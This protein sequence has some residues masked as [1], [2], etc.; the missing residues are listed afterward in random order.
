MLSFPAQVWAALQGTQ[1]GYV[2]A[3]V[4]YQGR[5]VELRVASGSVSVNGDQS[6]QSSG[7]CLV[8]GGGPVSLVPRVE[9][10]LLAPFGQ[11]LSLFR[12]VRVGSREWSVP[13]GTFG[14][15]DASGF[16]EWK[17]DGRVL[18]WAVELKFSD[19]LRRVERDD[20][21]SVDGPQSGATVWD[22]VARL[23]PVPIQRTLDDAPVS[24]A[25]TYG[26]RLKAVETLFGLLDC[27][28]HLTRAGVLTARRVDRWLT[29][30]ELDF[31]VDA[32]IDWSES[33]SGEFFN[34]VAVSSSADPTVVGFAVLDDASNPLS[35]GR[36]GG[37][38]LK[39]SSPLYSTP[40]EAQSGAETRLASLQTRRSQVVSVSGTP[41]LL[42]LEPGDFGRFSDPVSGRTLLGEVRTMDVPLD[43]TQPIRLGL[44]TRRVDSF[45]PA[46]ALSGYGSGPYGAGPYGGA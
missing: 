36:A 45:T 5:Q 16:A 14:I 38:T 32:V 12:V 41:E 34:Q 27:R 21:L 42:L 3:V 24:T 25:V 33:M 13:L 1:S 18:A 11:E 43:V 2:K 35:V 22:E 28:P 29:D 10:D 7:S 46:V 37:R 9:S 26:S 4:S 30:T 8:S 31:E 20:F 40:G 19:R 23:S 44:L 6:V 17:R 15:D 39:H